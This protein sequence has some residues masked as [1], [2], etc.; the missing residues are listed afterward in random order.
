MIVGKMV[1]WLN[2]CMVA[3]GNGR[4]DAGTAAA[5]EWVNV[6]ENMD[7]PDVKSYVYLIAD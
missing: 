7:R 1:V 5:L 6:V 4:R 3:I 2:G